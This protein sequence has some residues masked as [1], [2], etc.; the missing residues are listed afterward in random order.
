MQ[1]DFSRVNYLVSVISRCDLKKHFL[2][3]I[4]ILW[5]R[6]R[7]FHD[8]ID[9]WNFPV[10]FMIVVG[11]WDRLRVIIGNFFPSHR[12]KE[13]LQLCWK[14]F[15]MEWPGHSEFL[16]LLFRNRS[17]DSVIFLYVVRRYAKIWCILPVIWPIYRFSIDMVYCSLIDVTNFWIK[18]CLA[19]LTLCKTWRFSS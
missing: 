2:N 7:R 15:Q 8:L 16:L 3:A 4:H 18:A 14:Y 13:G 19:P 1:T 10:L 5:I 9:S 17:S 11:L 12:I 6:G